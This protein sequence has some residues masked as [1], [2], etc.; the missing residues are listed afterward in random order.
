[1]CRKD[2]LGFFYIVSINEYVSLVE[3][4]LIKGVDVNICDKEGYIVF[5]YVFEKGYESI[6]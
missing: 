4:L 1:M 3:F 5:V 6:K 2:G